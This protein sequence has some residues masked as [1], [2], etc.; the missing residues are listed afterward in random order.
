MGF[1]A[2][3]PSYALLLK[4][5]FCGAFFQKS[6][7]L[8]ALA[9]NLPEAAVQE[10]GGAEERIIAP[11]GAFGRRQGGDDRGRFDRMP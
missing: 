2:L 8:L 4:E 10:A 1:A 3:C 6:D 9:H 5:V 11:G 7:R